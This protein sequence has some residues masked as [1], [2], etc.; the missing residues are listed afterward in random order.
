[1]FTL[2]HCIRKSFTSIK[3]HK[4]T[5]CKQFDKSDNYLDYSDEQGLSSEERDKVLATLSKST[6]EDL[7]QYKISRNRVKEILAWRE[8]QG[9]FKSFQEV[10]EVKGIK[11]NILE[12]I[13]T[14][15]IHGPK[16]NTANSKWSKYLKQLLVPDLSTTTSLNLKTAVAVHLDPTGIG[17]AKINK[18]RNTLSEWK[19]RCFRTLPTKMSPSD[20]FQ[21]AVDIAKTTP[22]GD[23]YIFEAPPNLS[24]QSQT[25]PS[26]ISTHHQH[27]ELQAMLLALLN[28][29]I[30]HN[31][32]LQ[33]KSNE[34]RRGNKIFEN[35]VFYL[36]N[37]VAS[38]YA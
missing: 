25:K 8:K 31:Q 5:L 11:E 10:L 26:L 13:C 30:T 32:A 36:K 12:E 18:D 29:S 17:W 3:I 9:P 33:D 20:T 24:P 14:N 22:S 34:T 37:K 16:K 35:R 7:L 1:M 6:S 4:R 19:C 28:T 21:L 15:I 38:R 27:V 2:K 23:V